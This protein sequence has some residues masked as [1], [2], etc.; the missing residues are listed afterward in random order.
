MIF[1]HFEFTLKKLR[2]K[3]LQKSFLRSP[4]C[5]DYDGEE[6]FQKRFGLNEGTRL[7]IGY[8]EFL[9]K[10]SKRKN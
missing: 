8:N 9:A 5:L 6:K 1:G 3:T 10:K 4:M 2:C 7:I